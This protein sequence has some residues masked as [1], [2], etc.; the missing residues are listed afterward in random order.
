MPAPWPLLRLPRRLLAVLGAAAMVA[1]TLLIPPGP[2]VATGSGI[3]TVFVIMME[4]TDWSAIKGNTSQAPYINR[5]LLKSY[6][7]ADNYVSGYHPS[8]PN[9]ITLEAGDPMG[10]TD[11][12]YLPTDHSVDT[13]DH[14]TTYLAT[15]GI[16]WKYYAEN[17]PGNGTTCNLSDPGAPYSEDH[18]PFVYFKDVQQDPQ[19]CMAH[20]RP[21]AELANDL[22]AGTQPRYA[23]IV[24]NDY[25]QGEKYAA[26]SQCKLCQADKWLSREIP[27][28]QAS[29]A[30]K[31]NGA[32]LVLWDECSPKKS[33]SNGLIVVS[34]YAKSGYHNTTRYTHAS[35]LRSVQEIF[36]V[37]PFLR[38]AATANDLQA[39]FTTT[40][41]PA[42]TTH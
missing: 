4:N 14:L 15:A 13:P 20:E 3:R 26:G 35:T 6:A 38:A 41:T 27:K 34:Q 5:T 40:L 22:A 28:I 36:D 8:L 29:S 9:Y 10:M 32:I 31:N 12:A 33:T 17:L 23:M 2:A 24:P 19:Y 25:D 42:T 37:G 18:N 39:L 11:G 21:Y 1:T 16:S 7:S 30:Y